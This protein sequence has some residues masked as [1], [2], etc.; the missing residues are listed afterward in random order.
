MAILSFG[1]N[2][3]NRAQK[4]ALFYTNSL[5]FARCFFCCLISF[6]I[7]QC[8]LLFSGIETYH[9]DGAFKWLLTSC[10]RRWCRVFACCKSVFVRFCPQQPKD[11]CIHAGFCSSEKKTSPLL[12]LLAAKTAPAAKTIPALKLFP[13]TKVESIHGQSAVV[14]SW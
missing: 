5:F 12:K 2:G 10:C 11:I 13:A 8:V 1:L 14:S 9:V 4:F 3:N 7:C 6:C